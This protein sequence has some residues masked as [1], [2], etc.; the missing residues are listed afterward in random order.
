VEGVAKA[1]FKPRAAGH[2][3][4]V[5][6]TPE[7]P[8]RPPVVVEFEIPDP[9]TYAGIEVAAREA[10]ELIQKSPATMRRYGFAARSISED[11]ARALGEIVF[12]TEAAMRLWKDWNVEFEDD[13][14]PLA[15][16]RIARLL[17]DPFVRAA[18][19][20]HLTQASALEPAEGNAS[21]ASPS[22]SSDEAP[23]TAAAAKSTGA[24]ARKG[25][26]RRRASTV[27]A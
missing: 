26:R 11:D 12:L 7:G 21:G 9:V 5:Q 22:M 16:P 2:V 25:S 24:R 20:V 10:L 3:R 17:H 8:G 18:W 6:L 13:P 23:P 27:P 14:G 1:V 19:H 15:P 4:R